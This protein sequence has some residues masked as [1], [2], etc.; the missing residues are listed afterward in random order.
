MEKI[1]EIK[2]TIEVKDYSKYSGYEIITNK[3]SIKLLISS[4]QGCCESWGYFFSEDN[5]D[6]FI[7]AE[8][9]NITLTDIAL[10]TK[11]L[12][13]YGLDQGGVM[14]VNLETDKGTLQFAAYN[15][16]NGFY[17]HDAKVISEQLNYGTS[18]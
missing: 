4:S 5:L 16:H 17:G 7:G 1:L 14:F 11:D 9:K 3:Q 8:L 12:P 2:E 18:L 15:S 13:D 6:D 10:N